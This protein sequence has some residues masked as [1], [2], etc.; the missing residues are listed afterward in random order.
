MPIVNIK[1]T[2][3]GMSIEQ[4][5]ALIEGATD[6]LV[7]VLNKPRE[8]VDVIIDEVNT[9]NWGVGGKM[10]SEILQSKQD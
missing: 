7:Q 6:L 2:D 3:Q 9:N 4:K 5:K 1:V 8:T 10:M